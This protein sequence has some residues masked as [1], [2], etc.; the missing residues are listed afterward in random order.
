MSSKKEPNWGEEETRVF[1]E[2]CIE[3]QILLIMDRKKHK[4]IEIFRM[5]EP[6]MKEKGYGKTADQMKLKLKTL[7]LSYFKCRRDNNVSGAATSRCA[8]YNVCKSI[9]DCL[10][11]KFIFNEIRKRNSYLNAM[12]N[13]NLYI[14]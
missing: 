7:K 6:Q 12:K 5:L 3:K 4:H 2:M 13:K 10:I 8:F 11:K 14:L 1:L 9:S